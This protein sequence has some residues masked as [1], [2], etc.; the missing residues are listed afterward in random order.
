M[1]LLA[2]SGPADG[3]IEINLAFMSMASP[4]SPLPLIKASLEV[5]LTKWASH[6]SWL[7]NNGVNRFQN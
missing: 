6:I 4:Y 2:A 1:P 7:V 3:Q 5:N